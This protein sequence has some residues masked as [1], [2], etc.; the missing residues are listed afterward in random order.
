MTYV[1]VYEKSPFE[2][3]ESAE[4]HLCKI[5]FRILPGILIG[6]KYI[7]GCMDRMLRNGFNESAIQTHRF[8][9]VQFLLFLFFKL[10]PLFRLES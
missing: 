9:D 5:I 8:Q 4:L 10:K 6:F 3:G 1:T 2:C 7:R